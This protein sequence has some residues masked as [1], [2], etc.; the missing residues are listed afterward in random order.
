MTAIRQPERAETLAPIAMLDLAAQHAPIREEIEV[1]IARVIDGQ[2]FILGEELASF[3][4]EFARHCGSV[5]ALGCAS[6][7]DALLLALMALGVG[8]GD[9]VVVPAYSF[10]APA[11]SVVRLGA[12]PVFADIEPGSFN[13]DPL[14]ARTAAEGCTRLKAILPVDLFGRVCEM[15]ALLELADDLGVPLIEDAAQSVGAVDR[16]QAR[17]GSRA[18]VGCFSVYPSKNL[19][20]LGDGGLVT[21]N[22]PELAA[23]I[24]MLRSHGART[25]YRHELVGINSRLDTLQAAVL[26]VKLR[27]LEV[28][29][30]AR[31]ENAAF[32]DRAFGDAGAS[33]DS[34][35][36]EP[37]RIPL[38]LPQAPTAPAR[39]VY[40]HY[41]V[42]VPADLRD[43]LRVHLQRSGI[44]SEVYYPIGLHR[45]PCFAHLTAER[46]LPETEAAAGESLALP[47]HPTLSPDQLTRV[48]DH[49][50]GFLETNGPG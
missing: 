47:V 48:V 46:T 24:A 39:H 43:L 35:A 30:K 36:F 13:L 22:D 9:E 41:V 17:A 33:S 32:Y 14:E 5:T 31:R 7:T 18:T 11:S 40:H 19:G 49:V 1:A 27:Y 12:R 38:R 16:D 26:R 37:G 15:S 34:L 50:V 29:T 6:G 21:T 2:Q 44:A 42:R 10:V 4:Q 20:A 3:E 8:P 28:W 25:P 45:Q 23:R